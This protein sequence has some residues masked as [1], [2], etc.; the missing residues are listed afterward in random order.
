MVIDPL[1]LLHFLNL[2]KCWLNVV[3]QSTW[4]FQIVARLFLNKT[5]LFLCWVHL[6]VKIVYVHVFHGIC[7]FSV[8]ELSFI[9][10][11]F[12]IEKFSK[13]YHIP[14]LKFLWNLHTLPDYVTVS[15]NWKKS[16]CELS[17]DLSKISC[18]ICL[19]TFF[20]PWSSS[21]NFFGLYSSK[22]SKFFISF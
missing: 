1:G 13:V 6:F 21:E 11:S 2:Q 3:N 5:L 8:F 17:L 20:E 15:L 16:E 19:S 4:S 18:V 22:E 12:I 14:F 7:D 9:F 10:S